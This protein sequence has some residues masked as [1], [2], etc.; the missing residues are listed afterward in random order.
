MG[1]GDDDPLLQRAMLF[2]MNAQ[3]EDG[4]WDSFAGRDPYT[5]YH[6][7]M[8]G[9][10]GLLSRAA[11]KGFG[12]ASDEA[13]AIL[14]EWLIE[15]SREA[16]AQCEAGVRAETALA[17]AASASGPPEPVQPEAPPAGIREEGH[18]ADAGTD[19]DAHVNQEGDGASVAMADVGDGAESRG[20]SVDLSVREDGSQSEAAE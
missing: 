1:C 12:P 5:V 6:A 4:T 18:D 2:L 14:R 16:E 9:I 3:A 7:T 10:Q 15:D 20:S 17:A 8:V 13:G 11:P 19:T